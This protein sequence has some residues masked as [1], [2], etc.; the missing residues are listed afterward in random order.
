MGVVA[1]IMAEFTGIPYARLCIAA[2]IPALLYYLGLYLMVDFEAVKLNILGLSKGKLPSVYKTVRQGW[3]HFL[4]IISLLLFL[5]VLGYTPAKSGLLALGIML[6]TGML[7]QRSRFSLRQIG[8]GLTGSKG[9]GVVM[10]ACAAAGII[11]GCLGTS[12]LGLRLSSILIDVA[13]NQ[14]FVMLLI[15]AVSSFILGMGLTSI[16]CYIILAVLVA[17]ALVEMG[18]TAMAAHLFVFYFGIVSFITPPVAIA[19]FVA[20]AIAG[21][22]S[23]KTGWTATR[24]G[25][26]TFIVPFAF[27]YDSALLLQGS[28]FQIIVTLTAAVTAVTCLA[29]GQQRYVFFLGKLSNIQAIL[30]FLAGLALFFPGW[31]KAIGLAFLMASVIM[32]LS[33]RGTVRKEPSLY[34]ID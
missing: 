34:K 12:G 25:I 2:F 30:F 23:W 26:V 21:S 3:Y 8:T 4:P 1:F 6:I 10:P 7:A 15:T 17:P 24:L 13:E 20:S 32:K 11:I 5:V 18:A 9:M 14:F 16:P 28:P 22:N 27:M 19:A 29:C 33:S 31:I